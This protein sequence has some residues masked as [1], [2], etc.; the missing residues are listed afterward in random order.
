MNKPR[1]VSS[2]PRTT[3]GREFDIVPAPNGAGWTL[4]LFEGAATI[5]EKLFAVPPSTSPD[6][7][8]DALKEGEKWGI[9]R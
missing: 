4:R 6:A 8:L 5:E 7:V 1:P 3:P 9:Q 2:V